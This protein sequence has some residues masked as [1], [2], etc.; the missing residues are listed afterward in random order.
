MGKVANCENALLVSLSS[1]LSL[2]NLV[3][4]S[5]G[6]VAQLSQEGVGPGSAIISTPTPPLSS[7]NQ[8]DDKIDWEYGQWADGRRCTQ[9]LSD[10]EIQRSMRTNVRISQWDIEREISG[11][12]SVMDG[13]GESGIIFYT[14]HTSMIYHIE[15]GIFMKIN[16]SPVIAYW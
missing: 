12:V 10:P 8:F 11:P 14:N 1:P 4:I 2:C 15:I 7:H 9:R 13:P 16:C 3:I 6:G 5:V